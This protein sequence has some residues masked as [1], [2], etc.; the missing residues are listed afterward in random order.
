MLFT[1]AGE[2]LGASHMQRTTSIARHSS[3][4]DG[5]YTFVD[6]YCTDKKCDCHKTILTVIHDDRHVSTV[7]YGWESEEFYI[8][9]MGGDDPLAREMSGYST[10]FGSPDLVP[11]EAIIELTKSM[12]DDK[13]LGI[14]KS[15]YSKV[16]KIT[17]GK[18][19][20]PPKM[21]NIIPFHPYESD[22]PKTPRN[23]LC[24]CGSGK[25]YK[26]CCM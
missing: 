1:A 16:R 7:H 15:T 12:M 24:P 26:Q 23:A 9:W 20:K 14:I 21:D 17:G 2:I 11:P 25:K 5:H 4:P 18:S 22:E 8:K 10:D 13:W 3:L 19:S 6:T